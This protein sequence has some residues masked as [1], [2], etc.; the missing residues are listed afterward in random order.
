MAARKTHNN[1][2]P[3]RVGKASSRQTGR[4]EKISRDTSS[5]VK[6]AAAL[7]DEEI[8]S[9][10]VAAKQVQDRFKKERRIDP[11]DFKTSLQKFQVD[12]HEVLTLAGDRVE[13]AGSKEN[14]ELARKFL[15]HSHDVLDLA[16]EMVNIGAEL[17]NQLLQ[18]TVKPTVK[19]ATKSRAKTPAK[20][21]SGSDHG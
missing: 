14:S 15:G 18:K 7:L 9:G 21:A 19:S 6:N 8:A 16:V 3:S 1:S 2:E 4:M 11:E 20:Q 17:S 12:A 5:I 10:I 13:E